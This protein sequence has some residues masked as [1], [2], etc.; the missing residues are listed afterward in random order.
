LLATGFGIMMA[1][2]SFGQAIGT[3]GFGMVIERWG[4]RSGFTWSGIV[5]IIFGALIYVVCREQNHAALRLKKSKLASVE[6]K[7]TQKAGIL[8]VIKKRSFILGSFA[9]FIMFGTNLG[10]GAFV[11]LFLTQAKGFDLATASMIVGSSFLFGFVGAP[12]AGI[13]AD[14]VRSK[15]FC[16]FLGASLTIISLITIIF[17]TNVTLLIVAVCIRQ[18]FGGGFGIPPLNFLQVQN[19]AGPFSGSAMGVYNCI[20]QLG[21]VFYP[22]F[23]GI[24]L[25]MTNRNFNVIFVVLCIFLVFYMILVAFMEEQKIERKKKVEQQ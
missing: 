14:A 6:E 21:A 23:F 1:G 10:Y 8:E 19:T 9:G 13:T 16:A 25:D 2:S 17:A 18:M 22:V 20:C 12:L 4:W 5:C 7:A 11:V 15:K 24:I 3:G